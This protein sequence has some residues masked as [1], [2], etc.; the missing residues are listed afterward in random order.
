MPANLF[1]RIFSGP[2]RASVSKM[3]VLQKGLQ[4]LCLNLLHT[5]IFSF[6]TVKET[7][8]FSA[9]HP[10]HYLSHFVRYAC[11]AARQPIAW[12]QV[13]SFRHILKVSK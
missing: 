1:F 10:N 9:T 5:G 13:G 6:Y 2:T 3:C 8:L 11:S 4:L 7:S 12:Q